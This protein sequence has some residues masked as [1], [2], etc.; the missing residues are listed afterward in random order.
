M[1]EQASTA[2]LSA[3]DL[4]LA[5]NTQVVLEQASMTVCEGDRMGLVGR[6]GSGKSSFLRILTGEQK[7]DAGEVV[8]R[9][10]LRIGYLPQEFKLDPDQTVI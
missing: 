5:Y 2:L 1:S 9:R 7:A 3:Q 8:T 4:D 10:G 6:N